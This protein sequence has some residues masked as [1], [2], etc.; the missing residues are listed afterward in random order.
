MRPRYR[1]VVI[2]LCLA[3]LCLGMALPA[4]AQGGKFTRYSDVPAGTVPAGHV[5]SGP[6]AAP[7]G[8]LTFYTDRASFQA[9]NPGLTLEDFS[10][11]S[12]PPNSALSCGAPF[13]SSTNNACFTP[14]AIVDGISVDVVV[15]V[16]L[17][18]G[19]VLTPP[20]FGVPNVAVG[21]NQFGNDMR[22]DFTVLV[23][24]FGADLICPFG[25]FTF[26]LEI[27]G[28]GGSLGTTTAV[29]GAGGNFWGVDSTEAIT[30]IRF[31]PSVPAAEEG[32]L[33][34]NAEFG[35]AEPPVPTMPDW[36]IVALL[37]VLLAIP[38]LLLRRRRR[39]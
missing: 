25:P 32:E 2:G 13:N 21:P 7:V 11:T 15:L 20:I 28:S 16:G 33:I 37:V 1:D 14:G 23:D 8:G 9:A 39:A 12:V 24:A 19:V 22:I 6:H 5:P 29:C 17:G 18:N 4:M 38:T 35:Q 30:S 34:M 26:N 10:G 36:A 27:F 3:A 31:S